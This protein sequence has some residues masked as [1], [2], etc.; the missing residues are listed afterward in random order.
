MLWPGPALIICPFPI[1]CQAPVGLGGSNVSQR[2]NAQSAPASA[3]T[4]LILPRRPHLHPA[5][6]AVTRTRQPRLAA[7][8]RRGRRKPI[9]PPP[10]ARP[11]RRLGPSRPR[12]KHPFKKDCLLIAARF[13]ERIPPSRHCSMAGVSRPLR[14]G[15][16]NPIRGTH[17][18]QTLLDYG[19][20][21]RRRSASH[22]AN[23][24]VL[25]RPAHR[26]DRRVDRRALP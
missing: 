11:G 3:R 15:V 25:Q 7:I 14:H 18:D 21:S 12:G 4:A 6:R 16:V 22:C 10:A 2:K 5:C 20:L 17:E 8:P 23:R 1:A 19:D 13:S 24:H 26:D 9:C